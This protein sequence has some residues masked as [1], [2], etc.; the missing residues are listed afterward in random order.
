MIDF[1]EKNLRLF[2]N[3]SVSCAV[4]GFGD[5]DDFSFITTLLKLY[6]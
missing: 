1:S 4:L 5:E 6:L 3:W 2:F